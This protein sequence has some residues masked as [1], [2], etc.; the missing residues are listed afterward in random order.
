MYLLN[1]PDPGFDELRQALVLW[2]E[3]FPALLLLTVWTPPMCRSSC[4]FLP[5]ITLFLIR[6]LV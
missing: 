6:G 4:G 3:D 5:P 2:A 1:E